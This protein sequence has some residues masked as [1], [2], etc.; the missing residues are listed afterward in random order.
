MEYVVT[1][2]HHCIEVG[3]SSAGPGN[4]YKW[5]TYIKYLGQEK[6]NLLSISELDDGENHSED[7]SNRELVDW[8]LERDSESEYYEPMIDRLREVVDKHDDEKCKNILSSLP[9]SLERKI[10]TR[11]Y[12]Q[13]LQRA[14]E[15]FGKDHPFV[16]K[17]A[18]QLKGMNNR[19]QDRI[20]VGTNINEESYVETPKIIKIKGKTSRNITIGKLVKWGVSKKLVEKEGHS[21]ETNLGDGFILKPE[22]NQTTLYISFNNS[23]DS[24]YKIE[25]TES[26]IEEIE[27]L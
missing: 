20:L 21:V 26:Q 16:K 17:L 12:N 14:I 7:M 24:N 9:R 25:L 18:T 10:M 6:W 3:E 5:K 19:N 2:G 23:T 15:K 4:S 13:T 22:G 8:V 27:S 1:K 11:T